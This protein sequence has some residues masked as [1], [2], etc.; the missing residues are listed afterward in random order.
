MGEEIVIAV[1][2]DGVDI[3]HE[4][5]ASN[6][7]IVAPRDATQGSDDPRP[8]FSGDNHGTA[9]AGVACA[10]GNHGASG[11]APKAKLMPIRLRSGLGSQA[12]ADAFVW[13]ADNG[14]DVISCSWGPR[15]GQWWNPNDQTHQTVVMLPDSTR[16]AIDHA[17]NNGRNGK[18]CVITWAAGNGNENVEN[19]GYAGYEKVIT[20]A[21]CND[22]SRRSVYSDFGAS[23]W[24]AFPSS[25]FGYTPFDHPDALTPGI[26]T[27]NRE[28]ENGYNPGELNPSS[29]PPG[30]DH[31]NYTNNFGGTSS[32]C[33]GV[34]GIAALILAVNPA[35]T[36]QQVKSLI[37]QSCVRIDVPNGDY[38]S[39]GHS[40]FYGY[41]RPD[42]GRAVTLV[43]PDL[44]T[45]QVQTLTLQA[46]TQGVLAATGDEKGFKV[47][48]GAP[49]R[50]SLDGP[51]GIDFDLYVKRGDMPTTIVFDQRAYTAGADE[52]LTIEPGEPGEFYIMVRSY[53]GSGSFRLWVEQL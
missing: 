1:I 34:A 39:D 25:D 43:M 5:F 27:T 2:D 40:P 22:S 41:G 26:W 51:D 42:A 7:K 45:E 52:T 29:P 36:W 47:Q 20:V 44:E 31:G 14:A 32:A 6:G 11:V 48:L 8:K 53:Q 13:A 23:V 16:L 49:T 50:I 21:A 18:G 37:R 10:D 28:G 3:D 4:E 24:C 46:E 35:L 9:C 30:D 17:I 12:E 38:N 15:D 19:D 33:P